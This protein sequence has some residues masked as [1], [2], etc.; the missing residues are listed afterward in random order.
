MKDICLLVLKKA[1]RRFLQLITD[2]RKINMIELPKISIIIPTRN[3]ASYLKRGLNKILE[4]DYPN[5]EIIVMDGAS[6]DDTVQVI[7]SY[8][9]K[10]AKWVS[11]LDGG[12]YDALNKGILLSSGEYIMHFTDDD[13]I[14]PTS[15]TSIGQ[16]AAR[17]QQ[18]DIIFGQVN[19]WK[20]INGIPVQYGVT[21]YLDP[22]FVKPSKYFR[23]SP[24]PPTQGAF[25]HRRLYDRIGLH[26]TN[27]VIGDYEFW[28]RAIRM[29]AK[30]A[31]LPDVVAD[32]HFTGDN[33]VI[34]KADKIRKDYIRIANAYGANI[35]KIYIYIQVWKQTLIALISN[36]SHAIGF[37]PLRWRFNMKI[38]NYKRT[39]N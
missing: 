29:G 7:K 34:T 32:Y 4:S 12:E 18:F 1:I 36:M 38:K 11:K 3:R 10:I 27:Y 28:G 13:V 16:F 19:L 15:L 31:L 2:F 20:E 26:A 30:C 37:H 5:L 33:G 23:I 24:G 8:G 17:N 25:V 21:K 9:H 35:D 14:I 39:A 22:N 6:S